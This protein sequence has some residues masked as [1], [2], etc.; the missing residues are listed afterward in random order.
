MSEKATGVSSGLVLLV[1]SDT[2]GRGDDELGSNLMTNFVY[3][4]SETSKTPEFIVLM[5]AGAKLAVEGSDV[6][7]DL[8]RLEDKGATI[9]ACGTCLNYFGIDEQQRVG[10]TSNMPEITNTLLGADNV[11]TI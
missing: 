3:H 10:K 5:N 2:I 4:L 8:K 1:R 6:L 11:I 7:D 9:L